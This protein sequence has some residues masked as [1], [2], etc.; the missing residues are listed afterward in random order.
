MR[1]PAPLRFPANDPGSG[2]G[3]ANGT[4]S[5]G[6]LL[7]AAPPPPPSRFSS[8][9]RGG[10]R[11]G[12][13]LAP[14]KV[15]E[16]SRTPRH[17][18]DARGTDFLPL[19]RFAAHP[20]PQHRHIRRHFFPP[21]F[22][23][24]NQAPLVFSGAPE[25]RQLSRAVI[26]V[27]PTPQSRGRS[28]FVVWLPVV[29]PNQHQA[30]PRRRPFSRKRTPFSYWAFFRV[31]ALNWRPGLLTSA[32]PQKSYTKISYLVYIYTDLREET[33]QFSQLLRGI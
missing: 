16:V 24:R 30:L 21:F 20:S 18:T 11:L 1:S 33:P 29:Y 6:P 26:S 8:R 17:G 3:L 19:L 13:L 25:E 23:C 22:L 27:A 9:R 28:R 14:F 12:R 15:P 7:R 5:C 4:R 31:R 2:F 32:D 10:P